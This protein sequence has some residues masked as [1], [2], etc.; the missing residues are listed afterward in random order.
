MPAARARLSLSDVIKFL[1]LVHPEQLCQA[2]PSAR[3]AALDRAELT[4]ADPGRLLVGQTFRRDE[5]QGLP[6]VRRQLGEGRTKIVEIEPGVLFGGNRQLA[7]HE[8]VRVFDL[9]PNSTA[10]RVESI[11]EDREKPSL[12]LVPGAN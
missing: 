9:A 12:A 1:A 5:K 11:A 10:L 7:G 3:D 8:A 2:G 6:L 4:P